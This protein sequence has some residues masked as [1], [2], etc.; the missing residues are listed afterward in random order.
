MKYF[1]LI[2]LIP[3]IVA[4]VFN[5]IQ[6]NPVRVIFKSLI[7][8][9]N[10]KSVLFS[11]GY[12]VLII[13]LCAFIASTTGFGKLNYTKLF[14]FLSIKGLIT[15]IIVVIVNCFI[16]SLGEELGW[17]GYLL[18]LLTKSKGKL[19]A[20]F[21]VSIVWALYHMPAL[22]LLAKV[23]DVGNP[24]L[25]SIIQGGTAFL[26]NFA[27]SYCFYLS[28]SLIPVLLL[29]TMWNYLNTKVLGDIY[30]NAKGIVEGNILYINGE[31]ILGI[32]IIGITGL[33]FIKQIKSSELTEG[34]HP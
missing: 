25:V 27:F 1:S 29:H 30:V 16:G 21:I 7:T 28:E 8:K 20:T 34:R 12:P 5:I 15:L 4:I 9:F 19:K 24:V 10:M 31:G 6:R 23:T 13:F 33:W 11:I 26:A 22:F 32:I 14:Q 3:G 17:R 18:P 2:M